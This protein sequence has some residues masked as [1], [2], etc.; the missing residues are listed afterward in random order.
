MQNENK[1][2]DFVIF[3]VWTRAFTAGYPNAQAGAFLAINQYDELYG[4]SQFVVF[5]IIWHKHGCRLFIDKDKV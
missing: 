2:T 4:L 1:T 3:S 5:E